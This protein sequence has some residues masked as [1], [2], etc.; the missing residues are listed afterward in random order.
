LVEDVSSRMVAPSASDAREIDDL[1]E[2]D[3][4]LGTLEEITG[5]LLED[6]SLE[7]LLTDVLDL[8]ADAIEDCAAASITVSDQGRYL[9]AAS[10][11]TAADA[12]DA[13]Q[14][15]LRDGPCID[16]LE[17]GRE[18][19]LADLTAESGWPAQLR[20]RAGEHGFGALLALPLTVNGVTVGAMN[21]FAARTRAFPP[22]DRELA[23]RLARPV[24]IAIANGRAYRELAI[25]SDQLQTALE[26]RA[27]IEQAKGIIV[28]RSGCSPE[29]AFDLLRQMSQAHN[30]KLREIA[31]ALVASR[32]Q[33][34]VES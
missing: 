9:T 30:R 15:E 34:S 31:G 17:T 33:L 19:F 26:S 16:A 12:V 11:T 4:Y 6:G 8:V 25:L 18:H 13:M 7:Q 20:E 28:A 24:A 1:A 23:W 2:V 22:H 3:G 14:Y 27:V 21:L 5:L 10:T 29:E 32:G